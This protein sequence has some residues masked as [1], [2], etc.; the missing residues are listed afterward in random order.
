MNGNSM[1]GIVAL[2]IIVGGIVVYRMLDA[3]RRRWWAIFLLFAAVVFGP[4][5]CAPAHT[6]AFSSI[7][8]HSN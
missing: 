5:F 2:A 3:G 4:R 6:I 1:A 8:G 7:I